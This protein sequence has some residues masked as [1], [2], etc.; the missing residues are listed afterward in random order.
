M[1]KAKIRTIQRKKDKAARGAPPL[2]DAARGTLVE[3]YLPCGKP[4]CACKKPGHKGHGPYHYL[5]IG[6]P[7]GRTQMTLIRRSQ[8]PRVRMWVKHYKKIKS[9]L[10][11]V[12]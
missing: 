10:E 12:T 7:R 3:R 8:V 9:V 2:E 6:H 5:M 11:K 1:K 4:G